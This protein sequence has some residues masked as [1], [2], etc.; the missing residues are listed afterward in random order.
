MKKIAIIGAGNMGG[1]LARGWARA[2]GAG[3][4]GIFVANPSEDKLRIL[5]GEFGNI[6]TTV[7]NTEAARHA[8]TVVLAVKP[9]KIGQVLENLRPEL[10][11]GGKTLVSV[12]AGITPQQLGAMLAKDTATRLP[13]I[14]YAIPNIAVATGQGMTFIT[15]DN[16]SEQEKSG[17][18]ALFDAVGVCMAVEPRQM[19]AG[20]A[21]ASCGIAYA[22]RYIRAA[23]QGGVE[24]GLTPEQAALAVMQTLR[25]AVSLL[26]TGGRHPEQEIDRV[27]TAGGITI[28]GLNAMEQHGFSASVIQGLKASR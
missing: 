4:D 21:V 17:I 23:S 1:A 14:F 15:S 13:A 6:R 18:K 25:G 3:G 10:L 12:A 8:D 27:T 5:A 16:A 19:E 7:S 28:K 2:Q 9:W 26:E 11:S 24:L 20:T 22:L